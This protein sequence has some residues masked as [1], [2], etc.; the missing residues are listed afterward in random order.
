M[1]FVPTDTDDR[2][3]S[4]FHLNAVKEFADNTGLREN[5]DRSL[6]YLNGYACHLDDPE[7]ADPTRTV[8]L[9]TPDYGVFG[10]REN[11]TPSFSFVIRSRKKD[12]PKRAPEE[13]TEEVTRNEYEFWFNGGLLFYGAGDSGV[14]GPN[15]SVRLNAEKAGWS[16]HT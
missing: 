9:L 6:E 16:I 13:I 5:L 2:F 8:V 14:G 11:A 1:L 4:K 12:A 7:L 10:K 15:F 3:N